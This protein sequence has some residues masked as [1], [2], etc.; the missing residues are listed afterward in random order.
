MAIGFYLHLFKNYKVRLK[1]LIF[2]VV[3]VFVLLKIGSHVALR[4]RL[5]ASPHALE[6]QCMFMIAPFPWSLYLSWIFC[7]KPPKVE[8]RYNQG[9]RLN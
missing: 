2:D 7:S 3:V 8:T 9:C 6:K 1:E 4:C 5:G